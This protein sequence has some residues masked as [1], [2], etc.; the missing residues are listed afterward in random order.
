MTEIKLSKLYAQSKK[1]INKDRIYIRKKIRKLQ[2]RTGKNDTQKLNTIKSEFDQAV[3]RLEQRKSSVPLPEFDEN[4][5]INSKK[6][7]IIET[8]KKNQVVIIAG[9]TGSGKT[10]QI[11]KLCIEAG[12][13]IKGDIACTQPRRIAAVSVAQ[14]IS[15][16]L[17]QNT[18]ETAGYKVRFNEVTGKNT[19]I[20]IMTDGILL[21][22]TLSDRF[23]NSYDTIIVDEA[24]ERSLNIDFI[25]GFLLQLVKKRKD[26]KLI[27]TSAT[28]DTEKFSKVFD[29]APVIEVSGR[30][31]PVETI[32]MPPEQ[33]EENEE[34]DL[35]SL[36]ANAFDLIKNEQNGD[37]LIFMPTEN[38]ITETIEKLRGR[39]DEK[40]EIMALYARLP[41]HLQQKVFKPVSGRK[42]V[43]ATNVAETSITIPGIK[44][45]IDTGL[46]RIPHYIP[47]SRTTSLPVSPVSK[48]SA[49]QR[50]GRCGRVS[51]GICIRLFS[52]SDYESRPKFTPPE[53]LR[54]NLADVLLK[55]TALKLGD[56]KNFPFIDRP[57]TKNINDGYNLLTELGAVKET[58]NKGVYALTETGLQMS[59]VPLDP[60]LSRM[61]IKAS[62]L[63]C[64]E[65]SA[66]VVSGITASD[67]RELP[68]D[69]K[70][71]AIFAQKI[72][73]DPYS[74]FITLLNIWTRFNKE[75]KG[76]L[77]T[78]AT[79]RFSKKYYLSF[80]RLKEW[81]DLYSQIKD[82]LEDEGIKNLKEKPPVAGDK[83][84]ETGPL[85]EAVHKSILSGYLSN[86]AVHTEK[87]FYKG[88]KNREIMLFPGSG[89]FN[90]PPEWIVA[91]EIVET[92]RLFART[93]AM[94]DPDWIAA[95]AG[96]LCR[97][98]FYDPHYEKNEGRVVAY[99]QTSL[100]GLVL[101]KG[102]KISYKDVDKEEASKI[103]YNQALVPGEVKENFRF[104][105]ENQKTI[106]KVKDMEDRLRKRDIL[107]SESEIADFYENMIPGVSDVRTLSNIIR[108][109]GD[110][111]LI[112]KKEDLMNYDPEKEV[113]EKYPDK[114]KLGDENFRL[115][116]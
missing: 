98:T 90:K 112:M 52:Q 70:E 72:F 24:H 47:S 58:K 79:G 27:I 89:L 108:K 46:A 33:E 64:L 43:V 29:N 95:T 53:I 40:A 8:I 22:E 60:K 105:K 16:E 15:E 110:D 102:E 48:S 45:V 97:K 96:D 101:K 41:S 57:E 39:I 35:A 20:K 92:S 83:N 85:Y 30:M 7:E 80:R 18:G 106:S 88:S 71:K 104:I 26:L 13:G 81:R 36:A 62:E 55:M 12:L 19:I 2:K 87:K 4:L 49:D 56:I 111:F 34:T 10:T 109:K 6:D 100:Y 73:K 17:G 59:K 44:Y 11:P 76:R 86:I 28:I 113:K 21:A 82:I 99:S 84:A 5:P 103:F 42:I 63:G 91:A 94:V 78:G 3:K 67:P 37:T 32:Y 54:S 68:E 116:Y 75:N 51:N 23:L 77:T 93:A 31:Y 66:A 65:E 74:D 114:I 25:L 69:K 115:K 107:V 9:E 50:K 14:R 61:L 38:D 1:L